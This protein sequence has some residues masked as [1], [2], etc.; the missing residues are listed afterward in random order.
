MNTLGTTEAGSGT[1]RIGGHHPPKKSADDVQECQRDKRNGHGGMDELP[2]A[3]GFLLRRPFPQSLLDL[4]LGEALF[5][6]L[7]PFLIQLPYR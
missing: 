6:K 2:E 5:M 7:A 1:Y 3:K 4:C